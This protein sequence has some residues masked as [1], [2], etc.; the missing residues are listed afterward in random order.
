[1]A[2]RSAH[3]VAGGEAFEG[4]LTGGFHNVL[5]PAAGLGAVLELALAIGLAGA[6]ALWRRGAVLAYGAVGLTAVSLV[7]YIAARNPPLPPFD[8]PAP[9]VISWLG[10]HTAGQRVAPIGRDLLIPNTNAVYRLRSV[11]LQ[12]PIPPSRYQKFL[13]ALAD[14]Q[15]RP[16]C[17]GQ[18]LSSLG[19]LDAD[20]PPPDRIDLRAR[21]ATGRGRRH[22]AERAAR[23]GARLAGRGGAAVPHSRAVAAGL[24]R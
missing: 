12:D 22:R 4:R 21:P 18:H 16:D 10:A 17:A 5:S 3:F 8:F 23:P 13:A 24:R 6:L 20:C 14:P 1:M 9:P 19:R 7:T 11:G 2:D 15:G